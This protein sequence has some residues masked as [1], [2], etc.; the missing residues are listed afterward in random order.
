MLSP[1]DAWL[2]LDRLVAPMAPES[3]PR[4]EARNRVLAGSVDA[5]VDLPPCDMSAMDGY[6]IS[7]PVAAGTMLPVAGT[8]AAGDP[9]GHILEPGTA[10]RIMTGAP[11]P[12]GSEAVVPVEQTDAGEQAVTFTAD[13]KNGA[14][15]RRAGEVVRS[16]EQIL[17]TGTPIGPS[18]LG[19]LAA[20]GVTKVEVH[21]APRVATLSTGDEILPP[22]RHPGPGQL[23]DTHTDF[24]VAAGS[25]L[26]L[27]FHPLGIA[28]DTEEDL[29]RH[30]QGGLAHDVLLISGGVSKGIFDLVEKVLE[31]FGC[32][33]VFDAVA[34]QPGKPLVAA[35]HD[36]GW[37][38]G[39]PGN[40]ASAIVCFWLF[41]RPFL[42]RLM[43][44]AD[45]FWNGA[46]RAELAGPLPGAR[47]RT[48]FLTAAVEIDDGRI[49]AKPLP[50]RGSHD[51]VAYGH[52]A[53][54]VR[55]PAN[56]T[57]AKAGE[58][59]EVLLLP[60]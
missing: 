10:V 52:G 22:E 37:V 35:V 32:R 36:G 39:L 51:V 59:C 12:A 14:H 54:L 56:A 19:L 25:T 29:S 4:R 33:T 13:S 24:L 49:L 18:V 48:R 6:A 40:P 53:A 57:P 7:L 17:S 28:R 55:I 30:I 60:G 46:L 2:R 23:R 3:L 43:G 45:G 31:T 50:P 58:E 20:H 44:Y 27:E 38:F 16:G 9:P 41:V 21:G 8:I 26:G 5:N 34:I 11:V 1:E 47:G 15:I 42:R